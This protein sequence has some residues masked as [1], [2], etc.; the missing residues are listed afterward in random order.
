VVYAVTQ[1]G[2]LL[3]LNAT[4]GK[5]RWTA[6]LDDKTSVSD[7]FRPSVADGVVYALNNTGVA[8]AFNAKTGAL[9][10]SRQSAGT[11]QSAPVTANGI[12][13]IGTESGGVEAFA[14]R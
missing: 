9:L 11:L 10:W 4:T 6:N 7:T 8:Y 2:H 3:A 13:Y 5:N 1:N 14:A 12:L